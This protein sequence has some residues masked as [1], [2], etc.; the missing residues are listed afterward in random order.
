MA[1]DYITGQR[2][3][4]TFLLSQKVLLDSLSYS[5][6]ERQNIYGRRLD[7]VEGSCGRLLVILPCF[8]LTRHQVHG[9]RVRMGEKD[10]SLADER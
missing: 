9:L 7:A 8:R 10:I 6:G 4:R 1:S 3:P 2:Q 5:N